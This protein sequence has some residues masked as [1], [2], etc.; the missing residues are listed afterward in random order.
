MSLLRT[1]KT[2]IR[3]FTYNGETRTLSADISET[4]GL[5]LVYDDSIDEG[6]VIVG[7]TGLEVTFVVQHV[8]YN[9]VENEILWWD[10]TS[11]VSSFRACLYND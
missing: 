6:L 1:P 3:Q 8:E 4:N 10:L 7:T 11:T 9:I 2:S 5:G